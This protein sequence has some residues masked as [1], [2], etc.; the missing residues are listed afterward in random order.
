MGAHLM[1]YIK[2]VEVAHPDGMDLMCAW[3][4]AQ[5]AHFSRHFTTEVCSEH[6]QYGTCLYTQAGIKEAVTKDLARSS[7]AIFEHKF[8]IDKLEKVVGEVISQRWEYVHGYWTTNSESAHKMRVWR[9]VKNIVYWCH[10]TS[11]TA[12]TSAFY[13]ATCDPHELYCP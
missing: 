9:T 10:C 6:C 13:L 7:S 2:L 8:K 3:F 1:A 11:K 12:P 4:E 5:M